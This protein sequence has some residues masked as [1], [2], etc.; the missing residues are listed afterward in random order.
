MGELVVSGEDSVFLVAG[1]PAGAIRR[2]LSDLESRWPEVR[3][4]VDG[5]DDDSFR[6]WGPAPIVIPEDSGTILI[7]RDEKMVREWDDLGYTLD[8]SGEGP[9]QVIYEL[10]NWNSLDVK[11]MQ[12]PM[13]QSGFRFEP[14][15]ATL[16]GSG[17][18][19]VSLVTPP[20]ES[21]FS[22]EM[23]KK[24]RDFLAA[25]SPPG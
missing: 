9:M 13:E 4:W 10:A 24:L 18:Y 15:E 3:V 1:S 8:S 20:L 6:P 11:V 2:F 19:M 14:Y 7:A 21:E 25:G 5:S 12:D 16:A 23:I 17:F 22:A